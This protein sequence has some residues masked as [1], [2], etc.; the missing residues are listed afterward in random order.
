MHMANSRVS[1]GDREGGSKLLHGAGPPQPKFLSQVGDGGEGR[2]GVRAKT[3]EKQTE[4]RSYPAPP[5]PESPQQEQQ[6][7]GFK[8]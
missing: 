3:A 1:G 7:K 4:N 6:K 2:R 5:Y 8:F